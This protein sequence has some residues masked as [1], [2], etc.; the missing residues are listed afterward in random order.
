MLDPQNNT[1]TA[2]G[3]KMLTEGREYAAS[4]EFKFQ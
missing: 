2:T 4:M 3:K 1:K